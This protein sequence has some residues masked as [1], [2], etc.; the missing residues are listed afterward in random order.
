MLLNMELITGQRPIITRAKKSIDK[1]KLRENM[2]IGCKV[3]LRNTN[4]YEFLD[5][6]INIILPVMDNSNDLFN[7]LYFKQYT[8]K[9]KEFYNQTNLN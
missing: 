8:L 9:Q 5:R 2:P 7:S 1:F 6:F 3:T 4:L